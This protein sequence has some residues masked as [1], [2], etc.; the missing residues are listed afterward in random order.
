[1]TSLT[2]EQ[3]DALLSRAIDGVAERLAVFG[4]AERAVSR[5][6]FIDELAETLGPDWHR[7]PERNAVQDRAADLLALVVGA[8]PS[9]QSKAADLG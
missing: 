5:R 9:A 1:M 2:V 4:V 3:I 8:L 7:G 6:R